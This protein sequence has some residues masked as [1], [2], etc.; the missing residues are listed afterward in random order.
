[1]EVEPALLA[2]PDSSSVDSLVSSNEPEDFANEQTWPT[3]EEM[4]GTVD[5]IQ[6]DTPDAVAGTTPKTVRRIPKGM[7]EY[8]AAWIIDE[9]DEEAD[10]E[11]GKESSEEADGQLADEDEEM[12]D[13][14][15]DDSQSDVDRKESVRFE[16]LDMEE[17]EAQQVY[18]STYCVE[19][20]L[21]IFQVKQMEEQAARRRGRLILPR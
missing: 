12:Q 16:D 6:T 20:N 5:E 15:V 18:I 7:S 1:M 19:A 9:D 13:M 21:I 14:P 17:E 2:E 8:Q 4:N 3:E 11:D 10:E